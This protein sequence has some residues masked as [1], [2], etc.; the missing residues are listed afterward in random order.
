MMADMITDIVQDMHGLLFDNWG[1]E[2]IVDV[3]GPG[4]VPIWI[5][6]RPEL[7]RTGRYRVKVDPDS[8]LPQ[9]KELRELKAMRL[10]EL[11]KTNPLI[12][13]FKLTQYLL[14][15][16]HGVQFDD[17]MRMLPPVGPEQAGGVI[18]PQQFGGLIQ[19]SLGQVANGNAQLTLPQQGAG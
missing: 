17:M 16:L 15:E 6:F 3:V 12:D 18:Q 1:Q 5:Q 11:L 19:Q 7:L 14:H 8:S 13:P 10:Y 2:Q 4:G 9:T